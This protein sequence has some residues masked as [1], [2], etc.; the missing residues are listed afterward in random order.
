M[1]KRILFIFSGLRST[2]FRD[3]SRHQAPDTQL[4]GMNHLSS[5]VDVYS[6]EIGETRVGRIVGKIIGFRMRH[7]LM[8]FWTSSADIV[9]GPSLLYMLPLKKIFGSKA[10][11]V[12]LNISL[13]RFLA[14]HDKNTWL[15]RINLYLLRSIDIIVSLS[16]VQ[17][18]ELHK[19]H[20]ISSSKLAYI[21]LG[22]DVLFYQPVYEGRQHYILS[23]GR[24]NGRDYGSVVAVARRMP[25]RDFHI[26]VSQRNIRNVG[27]LPPN[28][29]VFIDVPMKD[30]RTKYSEAALLLL[31]THPD[32][33]ADG[34][35]CS[36]QTVLLDAFAS[37]LPVIATRKAY[38]NE[39]ATDKEHLII[40]EPGDVNRDRK[41]VV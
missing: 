33:Y 8:Y 1:K 39:Y 24:D 35:D 9:F 25:E 10:K 29:K 40:C 26:V 20:C 12:L 13:N 17:Q 31:V 14:Q 16:T 5:Q 2:L 7:L 18:Q 28:V 36:G 22:V 19:R 38:I 4:Y 27:A 3:V 34:S 37:G 6:K 30:L 15:Y 21:P 41:S 32:G 23:V 11:F